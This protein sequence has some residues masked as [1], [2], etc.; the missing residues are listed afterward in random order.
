MVDEDPTNEM[1]ANLLRS[2][3]QELKQLSGLPVVFGG[4]T[5]TNNGNRSLVISELDGTISTALQGLTVPAGRGLGGAT[6]SRQSPKLLRD[7]RSDTSIT[8][9]FD[10]HIVEFEQITSI[11]AFPVLV[12]GDVQGVFYGALR[13]DSTIGD[14]AIRNATS[15]AQQTEEDL[16]RLLG[17]PDQRIRQP[18]DSG[19]LEYRIH[20]ATSQLNQ[21][22]NATKN[23]ELR[24][25][26]I[27]I[28]QNLGGRSALKKGQTSL[29]PRELETLRLVALG[30]RN[31]DIATRL[32]LSPQTV[33]AYLQSAMRKL[34]VHNRNAAVH[35]AQERGVL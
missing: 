27:R 25:H 13:D 10:L 34:E 21:I 20:R 9:D 29:A 28:R 11:F 1:L 3:L 19:E 26:L 31:V 24:R 7:Y 23:E 22:I 14:R 30:N 5:R 33:K 2:R 4:T 17:T 6:L 8:H 16:K 15:I 35:A 32:G 18:S 12:K